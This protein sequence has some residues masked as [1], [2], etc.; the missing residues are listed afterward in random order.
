MAPSALLILFKPFPVSNLNQ[1][2]EGVFLFHHILHQAPGDVFPSHGDLGTGFCMQKKKE[3]KINLWVSRNA[4]KCRRSERERSGL[5]RTFISLQRGINKVF[6]LLP[7]GIDSVCDIRLSHLLSSLF[8]SL[9]PFSLF[10][11]SWSQSNHHLHY[12]CFLSTSKYWK[13]GW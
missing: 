4:V 9:L 6:W 5:V 1:D 2:S 12:S 13:N 3:E 11:S 8:L 7:G 10:P